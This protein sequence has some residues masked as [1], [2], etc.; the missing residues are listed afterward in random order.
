MNIFKK[1]RL[2]LNYRKTLINNKNILAEKFNIRIDGA[3]RMY[4]VINVPEELVGEAY[5]LKTSDINRISENFVRKYNEDLSKF[6]NSNNLTELYKIYEIKKVDKY[7]YL[8]VI[9]F[10]LLN[11]AKLY[12]R[13]YYIV[14]PTIFIASLLLFFL[15]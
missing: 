6:L 12:N 10:S 11:S 4:T 5:S 2:F 9:G 7:S 3:Q 15:I 14:I 13:L 1:I 8:I